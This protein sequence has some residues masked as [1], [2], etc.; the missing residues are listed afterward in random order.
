[1]NVGMIMLTILSLSLSVWAV[2]VVEDCMGRL[3]FLYTLFLTTVA[4]KLVLGTML[5]VVS[6]Q[7]K[8]D[9]YVLLCF[10]YQIAAI[11]VNTAMLRVADVR[12][13]DTAAV[14]TVDMIAFVVMATV[15]VFINGLASWVAYATMSK[16]GGVSVPDG[17]DDAEDAAPAA[18]NLAS[19]KV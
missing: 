16:V 6:Y 7:T 4:F 10:F 14:Y 5:P 19:I 8:L 2:D 13:A 15:W 17:P 1:M 18:S 11:L 9:Q 12:G 3:T